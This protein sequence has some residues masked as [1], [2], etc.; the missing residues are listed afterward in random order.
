MDQMN[1]ENTG[2]KYSPLK[3][4]KWNFWQALFLIL[5]LYFLEYILGWLR[6]PADPGSLDGFIRFIVIGFGDTLLS[7]LL[8][9]FFLKIIRGSFADLGLNKFRTSQFVIGFIGGILL[10]VAV[11]LLGNLIVDSLGTPEPQSFA[12]AVKGAYAS[13]Q[14][15]LLLLLGGVMVPL[16]EEL[17]FRGL[18]YPPVKKAYGP[19]KG[20]ILTALFFAVF[21]F[22]LIRFLPLLLGGLVL[23]WMYQKTA[24]IWP[25]IIA[26]GTWNVLMTALIWVQK[27]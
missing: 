27:G 25:S 9:F 19:V 2:N 8:L 26:H 11:G 4:P 6:P 3:R 16:K 12:L 21:H 22:D 15:I 14:L 7:F 1:L 18:V 24:S 13:W 20:I 23:T 10:S 5:I 17:I